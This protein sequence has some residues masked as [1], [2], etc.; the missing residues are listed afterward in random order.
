LLGARKLKLKSAHPYYITEMDQTPMGST[1]MG[2]TPM[3]SDS[4]PHAMDS[5]V[6]RLHSPACLNRRTWH[7][8]WSLTPSA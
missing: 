3:G 5:D 7:G 2:S 6:V 4:I 8:E 1:P